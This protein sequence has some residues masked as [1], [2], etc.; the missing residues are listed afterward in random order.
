[1]YLSW[2]FVEWD[3]M[4]KFFFILASVAS[5]DDAHTD[6]EPHEHLDAQVG[7]SLT[8]QITGSHK[9]HPLYSWKFGYIGNLRCLKFW[10]IRKSLRSITVRYFTDK[11]QLVS[12]TEIVS[13]KFLEGPF[14]RKNTS[15]QW[16]LSGITGTLPGT[17]LSLSYQQFQPYQSNAAICILTLGFNSF[18]DA[19]IQFRDEKWH[20]PITCLSEV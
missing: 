9:G 7:S 16:N 10:P 14:R 1:M 20:L 3:Q 15:Y 13:E 4:F 8:F 6:E 19:R 17:F 18:Y 2:W 11:T 5:H 12:Q